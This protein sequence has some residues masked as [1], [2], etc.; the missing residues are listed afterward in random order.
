MS[1]DKSSRRTVLGI[2]GLAPMSAVAGEDFAR[3]LLNS[4]G[5]QTGF[6]FGQ[7]DQFNVEGLPTNRVAG[8]LRRLADEIDARGILVQG[9]TMTSKVTHEDF[10]T[11]T[12]T[13]DI[14]CKTGNI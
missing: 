7:A 11:H 9:M 4:D 13:I 14:A 8:A 6:H 12:I 2:L 1:K 5:T 3:P 10:L